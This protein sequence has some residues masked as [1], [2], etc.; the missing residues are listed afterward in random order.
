MFQFFSKFENLILGF[1]MLLCFSAGGLYDGHQQNGGHKT[2]Y[3]RQIMFRR[4]HHHVSIHLHH[5]LSWAEAA[6]PTTQIV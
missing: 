2:Q 5:R 3:R 6:A 1:G 4:Y